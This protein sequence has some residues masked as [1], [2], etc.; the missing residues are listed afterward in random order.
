MAAKEFND[1]GWI[2]HIIALPDLHPEFMLLKKLYLNVSPITG[3]ELQDKLTSAQYKMVKVINDWE[4]SGAGRGMAVEDLEGEGVYKFIDRDDRKIFLEERPPHVLY[5][6]HIAQTYG[7]LNNV[8]Q[9]LKLV[10]FLDGNNAP[11]ESSVR[12]CPKVVCKNQLAVCSPSLTCALQPR[13]MKPHYFRLLQ[14]LH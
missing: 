12:I 3:K 9:Q 14:R 7:I 4:R 10:S 5:L 2:P 6:R 1:K 11:T 13:V 8:R